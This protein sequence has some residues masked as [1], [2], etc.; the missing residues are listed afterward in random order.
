MSCKYA[1]RLNETQSYEILFAHRF[2]FFVRN[3]VHEIANLTE[4]NLCKEQEKTRRYEESI[5]DYRCKLQESSKK[6]ENSLSALKS[7][8]NHVEALNVQVSRLEEQINVF[9][10]EWHRYNE[11]YDAHLSVKNEDI[12]LLSLELDDMKEKYKCAK[13][14]M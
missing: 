4:D 1:S 9:R 12:R 7:K 13:H 5:D 8:E 3:E 14:E 2:L 11:E 6:I 10:V